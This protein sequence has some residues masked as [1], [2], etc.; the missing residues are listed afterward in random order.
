MMNR[1]TQPIP[2]LTDNS[3]NRAIAIKYVIFSLF[4]LAGFLTD[5]PAI[6]ELS[7][8]GVASVVGFIVF[9]SAAVCA[10][11]AWKSERGERWRRAEIYASF[12]FFAAT[13][14]YSM[15]LIW[16]AVTGSTGRIGVALLSIALLVIPI[17][18]T[19]WLIRRAV[20]R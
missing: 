20:K 7:G 18:R 5:I 13:S 14:I 10:L 15:D 17:W 9:I 2:I 3:L 11:S 12:F 8:E 6:R 4:G 19:R 16:L 1:H